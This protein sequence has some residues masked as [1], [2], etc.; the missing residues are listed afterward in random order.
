M[1]AISSRKIK[2]KTVLAGN[3]KWP[4]VIVGAIAADF[5]A[6]VMPAIIPERD[7][8]TGGWVGELIDMRAA[9]MVIGGLD[10]LSDTQQQKF[11]RLLK[12]R[13]A[14]TRRMPDNI[15]IIILVESANVLSKQIRDL[16]LVWNV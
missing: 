10:K 11:A 2:L 13:R 9:R 16:C 3:T 15:Q 8:N 12:D 7:L 1:A 6:P 5:D 4:L 14:G